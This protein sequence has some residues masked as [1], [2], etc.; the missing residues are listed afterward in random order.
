[1]NRPKLLLPALK[2]SVCA[3]AAR[4][5]VRAHGVVLALMLFLPSAA[6]AQMFRPD[7]T[8]TAKRCAICHF[9]WVYPFFI[10]RR[11][12]EL[13]PRPQDKQVA[14]P[15]MCF[16]CHDGSVADSRKTV[17]HD[18][19]HRTGITPSDAVT[20]PAEFPLDEDGR[21][22]CATC[23][24]PHAV[25]SG[26]GNGVAFFLRSTNTNSSFCMRCHRNAVGKQEGGN[27]P[28]GISLA[29]IPDSLKQAGSLFGTEPPNQIIC[30]TCHLPH[31]G[32]ENR[33][34][35]LSIED[36]ATRSVLCEACH[37]RNPGRADDPA[38]NRFSHPLDIPPGTGGT[39]PAAW[40]N[41]EKVFLGRNGELVC[42][43]CHKPH[44]AG[45]PEH[46]LIEEGEKDA[47]CIQCHPDR[48]ALIGSAHDL[49]KSAPQA[50]T[51]LQ[52]PAGESGPCGSCHS[53]H[54]GSAPLMWT[55]P[56]PEAPGN[57][58]RFCTCCHA[59][60]KC[61]ASAVPGDFSHPMEV[62][63]ENI[64]SPLQLPLFDRE[65][66]ENRSGVISCSTCHDVH[67]PRPRSAASAAGEQREGFLRSVS[68]EGATALCIHCHQEQSLVRGSRHDLT[69]TNPAF[70]NSRNQTPAAGGLCSP[71]HIAHGAVSRQYIWAGVS[72]SPPLQRAHVG[73]TPDNPIA[74]IC[75]GCHTEEGTGPI[76]APIFH[77]HP[78]GLVV[79]YGLHP[80]PGDRYP[81]YNAEGLRIPA[82]D[83]T[84]S[85]CH[86]PHRWDARNRG[87]TAVT[88]TRG[89][90]LT[91]FLGEGIPAALCASCH[92]EEALFRFLFYHRPV[93]TRQEQP[94]TPLQR[95]K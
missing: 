75:T 15:Q 32:I 12:G 33:F 19:G 21:L 84:C 47:L 61:A 80:A 89:D 48:S 72:G 7:R 6:P 94:F 54:R 46:L 40:T 53:A 23:H 26:D 92:G 83:I 13:M 10:E 2:R 71:C 95:K 79:P 81:L 22:Q 52:R 74:L 17:F 88:V 41:G 20:I 51:L 4:N 28:T 62:G 82:G 18:P 1:M 30:E 93:R 59:E 31:G 9:E 39:I 69:V 24:T 68:G 3:T 63:V 34:L 77:A 44:N 50:G 42:R 90:G 60:G 57:P 66:R 5:R 45:S 8:D 86:N 37:T 36:P 70:T 35:V 14:S 29:G 55:Q 27:H 73:G 67:V 65:G 58:S 78:A 91:S 16:S 25:A 56:M 64:R 49:R 43:T 11:D 87:E 76:T 38:L 85:T